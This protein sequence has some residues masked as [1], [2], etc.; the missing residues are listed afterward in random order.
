MK[1]KNGRILIVRYKNL[2]R[3]YLVFG[4]IIR[5]IM[6]ILIMSSISMILRKKFMN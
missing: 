2:Y 4:N 6:I 1:R 5:F 3:F